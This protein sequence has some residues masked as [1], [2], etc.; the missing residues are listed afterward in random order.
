MSVTDAAVPVASDDELSDDIR[1][2]GR[3]L[4]DVIRRQA[5]EPTFELVEKVRR[6]A[7]DARRSHTTAVDDLEALLGDQPITE[8]LHVIRAFDWLALLANAAEDVH[9]ERRRRHHRVVGTPARAGSLVATF[10]RIAEAGVPAELVDEVIA[11]LRVTPV[12]TA[13]PTEV[14]RQTILRVVNEVAD[15]LDERDR[16]DTGDPAAAEIDDRLTICIITLW[17]TALLRL[18]KLRVRD[19]ISEALRYYDASL[20]ETVPALT[21]ELE[22]M[23]PRPP[24]SPP[25]D[26]TGAIRMGS[27]IGGDRDGNPFVTADVLH[28]AIGQQ[29]AT[30]LGHHLRALERL[31]VELSMSAR[32][33]TPT[34]ALLSLAG[35]SGDDSP[36]RA[37]EPYR[38]ALRGMHARLYA[39]TERVLR[40]DLEAIDSAPPRVAREPYESIA[41]TRRRPRRRDGIAVVARRR[42]T[43]ARR[44]SSPSVGRWSCSAPTSADSTCA[45]TR[46]CT[47]RWLPNC[48]PRAGVC[49]DYARPRRGG[50]RRRARTPSSPSPRCSPSPTPATAS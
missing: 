38:R 27:W 28:F 6:T 50:P 43:R 15:L 20:F 45:R 25:V 5:G 48:S 41:R 34:E 33:I 44:R 35:S 13:H 10:E 4:G 49:S 40:G 29:A 17:Q 2:L 39:F 26:A 8:Q 21:S 11:E 18:S 16:L 9:L 47:S 42:G 24:G 19:E 12:I 46:G 22:S 7:V 31:S 36:F 3:L 14:R 30:A 23:A 1:L 37:D 32:L